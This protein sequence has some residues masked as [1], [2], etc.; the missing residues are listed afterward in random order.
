MGEESTFELLR[1]NPAYMGKLT[2]FPGRINA[3]IKML[4]S[5]THPCAV[6]NLCCYFSRRQIELKKC[7]Y[8]LL[9][10]SPKRPH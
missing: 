5:L 7:N 9:W 3:I 1:I 8:G 4:S 6:T 10:P 2:N